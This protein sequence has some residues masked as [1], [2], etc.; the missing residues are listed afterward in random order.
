[1]N[2]YELRKAILRD[3]RRFAAAPVRPDELRLISMEPAIIRA[4][5]D[6][7]TTQCDE[8]RMQG[9]LAAIPGFGGAYLEITPAGHQ[10]LSPEF[11][12]APFVH[13]PGAQK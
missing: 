11:P 12:Q 4:P 9:Y 13:G 8:L 3:Y 2:I 1:M 10:Q 7:V 6:A 5:E